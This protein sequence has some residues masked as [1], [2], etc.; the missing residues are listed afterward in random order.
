MHVDTGAKR[1]RTPAAMHLPFLIVRGLLSEQRRLGE[2][3]QQVLAAER[4]VAELCVRAAIRIGRGQHGVAPY[5]AH[6]QNNQR[7]I[8]EW[9][10]AEIAMHV[11]GKCAVTRDVARGGIKAS[12]SMSPAATLAVEPLLERR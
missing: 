5:T 8:H 2:Q 10:E 12:G 7:G 11:F 6:W 9:L 3:A 4:N 1:L